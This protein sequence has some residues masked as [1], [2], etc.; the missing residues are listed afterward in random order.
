MV[1]LSRERRDPTLEATPST[2]TRKEAFQNLT[3]KYKLL[4]FN[5]TVPIF[6]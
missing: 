5:S 1:E 2:T 6:N 3:I 4:D